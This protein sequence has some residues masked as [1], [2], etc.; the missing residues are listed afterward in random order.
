MIVGTPKDLEEVSTLVTE[1]DVELTK[2]ADQASFVR[3]DVIL[4]QLKNG[5]A[6]DVAKV[7][8]DM[9]EEQQENARKADP[10][11][12]GDP[13]V[14][15]LRL[16]LA[17]GRE[18]P[19]LNLDRPIKIIPEKGTNSLIVFS[20]EDN[21]E[22]LQAIVGVFDTLPIGVETDV[23]AFALRHA[24][25]EDVAQLV[26]DVFKDKSYLSRPSEGDGKGLTKG[27]LP[28][29]PPGSG[30]QGPAVSAR[31]AARRP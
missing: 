3:A 5:Q 14:K 30:G 17:D 10:E 8:T 9:I 27:V 15:V 18:L 24:A 4:I 22:A 16:R 7:L 25:A 29:V 23:K 19:E 1:L 2:D 12:P 11:K 20:T 21:N 13:F 6:E 28:P 26:E 31:R